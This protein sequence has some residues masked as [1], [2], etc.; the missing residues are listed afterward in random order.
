M[1][2][3]RGYLEKVVSEGGGQKAYVEGYSI[4]GK[5]GTAQKVVDGK[6][7]TGKYIASF[8]GMAPAEDPKVTVFISIDEPDPSNYYAG[9]I[10]TPIAKQVFT[11][12]FNYLA[13]TSN[14]TDKLI[15]KNVVIP[16]VR[17]LKKEDAIKTLKDAKLNYEIDDKGGNVVDI[18]PKPGY[19]I[20]EGGK[21]ILYTG[22]SQNYNKEVVVP[23]L[24]GYSREQAVTLLN[25]LGIEAKT[26]GTGLVS[27]Q[28]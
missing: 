9:Q 7:A 14:E 13:I 28:V 23:N 17:G 1:K 22:D 12:I 15:L 26:I 21:V 11:D 3:L 6:Y 24:K 4:A 18:T 19:S 8:G 16:E 20:N 10:A 5:T 27:N 2:R 25:K